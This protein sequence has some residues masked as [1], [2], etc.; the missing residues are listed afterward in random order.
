VRIHSGHC[1][2]GCGRALAQVGCIDQLQL[3]VPVA[4][5]RSWAAWGL[6]LASLMT[7]ACE[8]SWTCCRRPGAPCTRA[9]SGGR[10]RTAAYA[11]GAS[12]MCAMFADA[13]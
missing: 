3:L 2:A 13:L 10:H 11:A 5:P 1:P 12:T 8:S 9:C 6:G 7:T 4:S